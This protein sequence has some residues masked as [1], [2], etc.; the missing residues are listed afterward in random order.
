MFH[1][2]EIDVF[3]KARE[4]TKAANERK[5]TVVVGDI[6]PLIDALPKLELEL[7]SS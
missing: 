4:E 3:Q 5:K 7:V 2:I 6:H 1:F